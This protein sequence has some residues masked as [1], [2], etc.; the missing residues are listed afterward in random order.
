MSRRSA[1]AFQTKHFSLSVVV[2]STPLVNWQVYLALSAPL[3]LSL[4]THRNELVQ[5][6][7]QLSF[8]LSVC[9]SEELSIKDLYMERIQSYLIA[10]KT[11]ETFRPPASFH[12]DCT[13]CSDANNANA[14][15]A[16]EHEL[17]HTSFTEEL[18]FWTIV[19]QFPQRLICFLL[20]M[21]PEN[22]YK[23]HFAE[24]F[25]H[26]YPRVSMML[27]SFRQD[28]DSSSRNG[29]SRHDILSNCVVH[30]SVQLFSNE[31]LVVRLCREHHLLHVM[32]ASLRATIEGASEGP[33][34]LAS[35][36]LIRSQLQN[37]TINRHYVVNCDHYIMKKHSYW[38]LVSDLNNVLTHQPVALIFMNDI[39]LLESWLAF[40]SNF[41]SMSL[42]NRV[43][44]D[45]VEYENDSY[46]AAF[47]AELEICATPVWTLISHLKDEST[48]H[49]AKNMITLSLSALDKWFELISFTSTDTPDC[50]QATFHIPLHR[51]YAIF[52]QH[53][54]NNQGV[55]LNTL[56][57]TSEAKLKMYLAHPLH[58]MITFYEI[59]CGLWVR[60][61]LQM[62]AQAMTY[63]QCHFCNSLVDPDIFLIQQTA[64]RLSPDWFIQSV[65]ERFHVWDWLSFTHTK[66]KPYVQ[67][68]LETEQIMPMLEG[69]LTLLVTLFSV[70]SNLG[71][72]EGE[73]TRQEM[74]TLLAISDRT[75]SQL[76]DMLPERCGTSGQNKDFDNILK[77][78]SEFKEPSYLT[79]G[80]FS[81]GMYCPKSDVW[82]NEFDPI[83]VL[84][85]A[86]QRRDYQ[87]AM[88]RFTSFVK[89]N[90]IISSTPWP[91][92]R[93]PKDPDT[94]KFLDPRVLL[95]S[96]VL[97]S[98]IFT[99]LYKAL[100]VCDVT[101]QVL[102][103]TI[104]LVEMALNFPSA[105]ASGHAM[106]NIPS[107]DS[108]DLL[109]S[110]QK[111]SEWYNSDSILVNFNT[112]I[113]NVTVPTNAEE[114]LAN[115]SIAGDSNHPS[116]EEMEVLFS[117][118]DDSDD[119]EYMSADDDVPNDLMMNSD[120]SAL[121]TVGISETASSS[122]S[123]TFR[124][125]E[126]APPTPSLPSSHVPLA[127]PS[128]SVTPLT[129]APAS[130][131]SSALVPLL[132]LPS[133]ASTN[134]STSSTPASS[135]VNLGPPAIPGPST[136][137]NTSTGGAM[138]RMN[139][140]V[141]RRLRRMMRRMNSRALQLDTEVGQVGRR[142]APVTLSSE[143]HDSDL[144][145]DFIRAIP[146]SPHS[147]NSARNT[148]FNSSAIISVNE[149]IL[150][151]LL[152]LHSKFTNE[153][154]SYKPAPIE[155][156][157]IGNGVLFVSRVLN[158]Y[159]HLNATSG[160]KAIND[161]RQRIWPPQTPFSDQA[162]TSTDDQSD[163]FTHGTNL[164][165]ELEER[166][167]KAKERQ[168]KLMAEFAKKQRDFLVK[169]E[170]EGVNETA[171]DTASD[172]AEG[173]STETHASMT[174]DVFKPKEY[175]CVICNHTTPSTQSSL[176]G[177]VALLQSTSVLAHSVPKYTVTNLIN[178]KDDKSPLPIDDDPNSP[179]SRCDDTFAEYMDIR[180]DEFSKNFQA[181][182][183]QKSLSIGWE[184]GVHVQSCGHYLHLLCHK[185]YIASL[186]NTQTHRQ[187]SEQGEF[188]CPLCRQLANS[189]VP[190]TPD[191]E[192]GALVPLPISTNDSNIYKELLSLLSQP[193]LPDEMLIKSFANFTEDLTKAT[194]P[195]YRSRE[196]NPTPLGLFLFLCSILRTNL[197]CDV[198]V[199]LTKS[200][201]VG[202]KK[203]CI[204]PLFNV[205][206]LNGKIINH[207]PINYNHLWTQL[208]GLSDS[209]DE[210][211]ISIVAA[212]KEVPIL[213]KDP[214]SLLIQL[215]FAL[216]LN[217]NRDYFLCLVRTLMNLTVIQSLAQLTCLIG[218]SMRTQ[219]KE[220]YYE[221]IS[222][223]SSSVMCDIAP[224]MG[225]I[226]DTLEQSSLYL[227]SDDERRHNSED[228]DI[229]KLLLASK[230]MTLPFLRVCASLQSHL[231]RVSYPENTTETV[232][233]EWYLLRKALSID[234]SLS[235]AF[236]LSPRSSTFTPIE[237]ANSSAHSSGASSVAGSPNNSSLSRSSVLSPFFFSMSWP[238]EDATSVIKLW[239]LEFNS[240][241]KR[242]LVT[243]EKL[244]RS[245]P[246][247][248]RQPRLLSLP[249][250]YDQLFLYYYQKTCTTCKKL[251]SEPCI[252]LVCGTLVCM[253]ESCCRFNNTAEAVQ[254]SESCGAGT[255]IF[256]AVNSS[257]I[258]VIR[259]KKA[260]VWGTVYLDSHGEEDRDL[261]RGKPLY[262]S[263]L[264]YSNLEQQWLTHSFDHTSK[265]WVWHK[266]QL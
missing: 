124:S 203:E 83:H 21:L 225:M 117:S 97:H 249:P 179:L 81:Q 50:L 43:I 196:T 237:S 12:K 55:K 198:L 233:E 192:A 258:I 133:N 193:S 130:S 191:G 56:L 118:S 200:S 110:D 68:F 194:Q 112:L 16:F 96:K 5:H 230:I 245:K 94:E 144:M 91:P 70:R 41:Q 48:Q 223:G 166:R 150:S 195:H 52:L 10:K 180:L 14:H 51:Y 143:F 208:T 189:V 226:I 57:P 222:L 107:E 61:G 33:S 164:R 90:N 22:C 114:S 214:V 18:L 162:S 11:L 64:S 86:V 255:A 1:H 155:E 104:H 87:S 67:G 197:E 69:A 8:S 142:S 251:P 60:N 250:T 158:T 49:L 219:L 159:V 239:C 247:Y 46:Y 6:S 160:R 252:C 204:S 152:K 137:P 125:I 227:T 210:H 93:L 4:F 146:L 169:M 168:Q 161:W 170:S 236:C 103:L 111:Y 241:A 240:M 100:Y 71:L 242:L 101:D 165:N 220:Y 59:L 127:L 108:T 206:A 259:S 76:F 34:D 221:T 27:A 153:A 128:T 134:A 138:M 31:P 256:L 47:S 176:I 215:V 29:S 156:S 80:N 141:Q 229:A 211:R 184:G 30:I 37:K 2:R 172:T 163:G 75:H 65:F 185:S 7:N 17:V 171:S 66:D 201:P 139:P 174:S 212:E 62:R 186:R 84:L 15:Y 35:G 132:N 113:T 234:S 54:V 116:V 149:S 177:M 246:L 147:S 53:A 85:R 178:D 151:L 45:H 20:N 167:R 40:I 216:P 199:K 38:P 243:A 266:D 36:I 228:W 264:R 235:S 73:I 260:C 238:V 109:I 224:L 205:L 42:N 135:P 202:A 95:F 99:I 58:V 102:A 119:A 190:L 24:A 115:R 244:L 28:E 148:P 262:L 253:R 92:F 154:D 32:L 9:D 98:V 122:S 120:S 232:E 39:G 188:A 217:L 207:G 126:G 26:H 44:G 145:S 187:S 23:A 248:L 105:N 218:D 63:V 157:R 136:S 263:P 121:A 19:Y 131:T 123:N 72:S 77:E 140:S 254:H 88:D 173:S 209:L 25:V 231:Y 129:P 79:G 106:P 74:V 265:R 89:N 213:L 13:L 181:A 257:T 78:I 261:K 3:S 182:S 82:K 175:E 183:W